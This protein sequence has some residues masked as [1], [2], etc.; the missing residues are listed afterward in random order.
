MS[1]RGFEVERRNLCLDQLEGI[2]SPSPGPGDTSLVTK[3]L[4]LRKIPIRRLTVEDLRL[5]I[6]QRE[7]LMFLMPLALE[8]L[9]TDP[10]A[11]GNYFPGDLL[12]AVLQAG[13]EYWQRHPD[14]RASVEGLVA[15]LDEMP[16]LV[17][18]AL[19]EFRVAAT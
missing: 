19:S 13:R 10:L 7:G 3:C 15:G 8:H 6:G 12:G 2:S 16:R 9:G 5:M 18:D 11:E 17:A 14:H 1:I 4:R